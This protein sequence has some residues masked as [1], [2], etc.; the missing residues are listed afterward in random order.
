M[1]QHLYLAHHGIKGMKWGVRRFR[2][3]DGTLTEAGRK[4]YSVRGTSNKRAVKK[5]ISLSVNS[6][7]NRNKAVA[8]LKNSLLTSKRIRQ[9]AEKQRRSRRLCYDEY[10]R[11]Y[12]KFAKENGEE[13]ID[14]EGFDFRKD[15]T[16]LN[17]DVDSKIWDSRRPETEHFF[18][19]LRENEVLR[20]QADAEERKIM[21]TYVSRFNDAL[22]SDVPNDGTP[23]AKAAIVRYSGYEVDGLLRQN[24]IFREY[25]SS[26]A[27]DELYKL[28]GGN[29]DPF[30][31]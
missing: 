22:V 12:N 1:E 4:R 20:S 24:S 19:L 31:I 17:S 3:P 7:E 21:Q 18:N 14:A 29:N 16:K 28:R 5:A 11:L 26:D 15:W 23:E 9:N 27:Y 30:D 10:A 6:R 13:T 8:E 2:N 25:L